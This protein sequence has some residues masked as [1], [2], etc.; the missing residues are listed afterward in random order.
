MLISVGLYLLL[1]LRSFTLSD[2][3]MRYGDLMGTN[4]IAHPADIL[5]F[6]SG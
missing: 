6:I 1:A 2:Q 5:I 4:R 3:K